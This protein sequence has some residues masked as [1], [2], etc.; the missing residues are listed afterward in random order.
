MLSRSSFSK[1]GKGGIVRRLGWA[2]DPLQNQ[3]DAA[4][5]EYLSPA[6]LA[7]HTQEQTNRRFPSILVWARPSG[8]RRSFMTEVEWRRAYRGEINQ[9]ERVLVDSGIRLVNSPRIIT[10]DEQLQ[11]FRNRLINSARRWSAPP[12]SLLIAIGGTVR[13][14]AAVAPV[15]RELRATIANLAAQSKRLETVIDNMPQGVCS[16]GYEGRLILSNRRYTEMYRLAPE[17]VRPA[18]AL[19]EIAERQMAAGHR[20]GSSMSISDWLVRSMGAWFQNPGGLSSMTG[21][22]FTF[23]TRRPRTVAE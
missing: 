22:Q 7:M 15:R 8:A 1:V 13:P 23:V 17:D 4:P 19:A 21:E 2:L 9:F 12:L 20:Q 14:K 5:D 16:F 18:P 6:V 10:P 3:S 11:R